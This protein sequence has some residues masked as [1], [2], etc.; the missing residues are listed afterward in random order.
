MFFRLLMNMPQHKKAVPLEFIGMLGGFNQA[1][2][3]GEF[4]NVASDLEDILGRKPES[5]KA[6]LQKVYGK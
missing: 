2:A 3:Q 4:G 6:F 1:I 5:V